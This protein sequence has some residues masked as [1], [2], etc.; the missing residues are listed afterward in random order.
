[1]QVQKIDSIRCLIVERWR[2]LAG[3][4]LRAGRRTQAPSSATLAANSPGALRARATP[5]GR[6][7][8]RRL[9]R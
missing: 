5:D 9:P 3:S 7:R 4:S 8:Y 2:Q 1:L 6:W